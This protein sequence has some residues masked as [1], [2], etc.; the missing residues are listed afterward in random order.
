MTIEPMGN[1]D[2]RFHDPED[3]SHGDGHRSDPPERGA[4]GDRDARDPFEDEAREEW[5]RA[6]KARE[7]RRRRTRSRDRKERVLHTRISEQLADDIRRV[8]DD[9]RVPVSNLVR[10]VLEEAFDAAERVSEDMGEILDDVLNQAEKASEQFQ[11]YQ[12]RRRDREAE[13]RARA[14]A[15]EETERAERRS[16]A[17]SSRFAGE[18][19]DVEPIEPEAAPN[20][21]ANV[22]AWQKVVLN[23]D[24]RCAATGETLRAGEK[25][26][27]GL[28]EDGR[29]GPV[30][31]KAPRAE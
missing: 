4:S 15:W 6:R 10:N 9:L 30:L 31:K 26:Y 3:S 1:D 25:A 2:D 22:V 12:S 7:D 24:R 8:A 17:R 16:D 13:R 23:T 5:E 29:P 20:P 14:E 28:R 27:L 11:R 19:E 21:F 18:A